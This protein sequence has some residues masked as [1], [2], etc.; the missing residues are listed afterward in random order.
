MLFRSADRFLCWRPNSQQAPNVISNTACFDS[1][2]VRR[3]VRLA[4]VA[5][6][7]L[8]VRMYIADSKGTRVPKYTG[9][10]HY[11]PPLL[12]AGSK[13][14]KE[15]PVPIKLGRCLLDAV[16]VPRSA[17][18]TSSF[19]VYSKDLGAQASRIDFTIESI[20]GKHRTYHSDR[21][22]Q[23]NACLP[24]LTSGPPTR[25]EV[26]PSVQDAAAGQRMTLRVWLV[27]AYGNKIRDV[28][29]LGPLRL[30]ILNWDD[31]STK[32]STSMQPDNTHPEG[33]PIFADYMPSHWR[34]DNEDGA[35]PCLAYSDLLLEGKQGNYR[36]F[37][38]CTYDT[39][40]N[41][42]SSGPLK[43]HLTH[44]NSRSPP[45]LAPSNAT[46]LNAFIPNFFLLS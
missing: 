45:P 22:L 8:S 21:G 31:E 46:S 23:S 17:S 5:G 43:L 38:R 1:R 15:I 18:Q 16:E 28:H 44:G 36:Y 12:A 13:R 10:L 26:E 2:H 19:R 34:I 35:P 32:G 40:K 11:C 24:S 33:L 39:Q 42:I 25:L 3:E 37:L 7:S 9:T 6:S 41:P 4:A 30:D 27:D 14:A 29:N 20:P